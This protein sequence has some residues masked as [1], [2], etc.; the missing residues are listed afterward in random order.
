[1][2]DAKAPKPIPDGPY[3]EPLDGVIS[4]ADL[5]DWIMTEG[6]R[7]TTSREIAE[8]VIRRRGAADSPWFIAL[9]EKKKID[10]G[11]GWAMEDADEAIRLAHIN[12]RIHLLGT[13]PGQSGPPQRIPPDHVRGAVLDVLSGQPTSD[14]RKFGPREYGEIGQM[15]PNSFV[16]DVTWTAVCVDKREVRKEWPRREAPTGPVEASFGELDK[17]KTHRPGQKSLEKRRGGRPPI[18][19][20]SVVAALREMFPDG[21][22]SRDA[23]WTQVAILAEVVKRIG[24]VSADTFKRAVKLLGAKQSK[25]EGL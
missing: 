25:A 17:P 13:L 16:H 18:K 11:L 19:R 24:S 10:R 12:R 20:D 15:R 3:D 21:V 5:R 9:P 14:K 23:R 4:L 2:T 22:P 7:F 6:G 8:A 1:M